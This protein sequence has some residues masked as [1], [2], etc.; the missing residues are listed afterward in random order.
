MQKFRAWQ[1]PHRD[2][3]VVAA[4]IYAVN[5]IGCARICAGTRSASTSLQS[6]KRL[7]DGLELSRQGESAF[8]W[9]VANHV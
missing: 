4:G 9:E 5:W 2:C 6:A 1:Y 3:L 8:L 7:A